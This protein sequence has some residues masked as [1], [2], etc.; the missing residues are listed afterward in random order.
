MLPG[1]VTRYTLGNEYENNPGQ[2]FKHAF[3]DH[4]QQGDRKYPADL[5]HLGAVG[6]VTFDDVP[7]KYDSNS[8]PYKYQANDVHYENGQVILKQNK[9][10]THVEKFEKF[11]IDNGNHYVKMS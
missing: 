3:Q 2:G 7:P 6:G 5:D 10:K 1:H 11:D 9:T 4:H 8:V